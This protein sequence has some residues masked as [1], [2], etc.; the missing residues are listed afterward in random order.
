MSRQGEPP[1][2]R[3]SFSQLLEDGPPQA[4]PPRPPPTPPSVPQNSCVSPRSA[5]VVSAAASAIGL[6]LNTHASEELRNEEKRG[7]GLTSPRDRTGRS[8]SALL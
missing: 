3:S 7:G 6:P 1:S 8:F 2:G 5:S 4:A